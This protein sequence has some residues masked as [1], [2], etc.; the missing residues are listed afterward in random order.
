V[1]ATVPLTQSEQTPNLWW[2]TDRA[3]CVATEIDLTW[4][5]V[6]GASAMIECL[7]TDEWIEAV[8]AEPGDPLT[9]VEDWVVR[10]ADEALNE[11]WDSG[12]A[13][14]S[15][16]RGTVNAWLKRPG[17]R[18]S[19]M[20]LTESAGDNGVRGS[21]R[22]PLG[23]RKEEDLREQVASHLIGTVIGLVGG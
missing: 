7:F 1:T 23:P 18:R 22:T 15:T 5:Y 19:G 12:E 2:P 3:W 17:R 4:T 14:I 13:T 6:G 9:R 21:S 11:L 16:S 20:L 10:W 8:S